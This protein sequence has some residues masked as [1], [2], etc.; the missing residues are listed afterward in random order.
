MSNITQEDFD[1]LKKLV[2]NID[3]NQEGQHLEEEVKIMV[4]GY[5]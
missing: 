1:A 4:H 2:N 3:G 5:V